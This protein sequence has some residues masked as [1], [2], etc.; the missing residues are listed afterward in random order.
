V[1]SSTVPAYAAAYQAVIAQVREDEPDADRWL[2]LAMGRCEISKTP[3]TDA[4]LAYGW[5]M[6]M[7]GD[8]ATV[9]A[10]MRVCI[11][12]ADRHEYTL[13]RLQAQ[14]MAG[15]ARVML[16]DR[17]GMPLAL[18]AYAEYIGTGMRNQTPFFLLLLAEAHAALGEPALALQ[19]LRESEAATEATGEV[20]SSP[21]LMAL[22]A[23]LL[24]AA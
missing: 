14:V 18:Q 19:R 16:G 15:W 1:Y 23:S 5:V 4:E 10:H 22:A 9:L 7:R 13:I 12:L 21:R 6:A 3:G 2:A 17:D 24:G 20:C 11:E 8:A